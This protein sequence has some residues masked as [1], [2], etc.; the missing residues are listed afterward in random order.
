MHHRLW[1]LL[2]L[3]L[4]PISTA[5]HAADTS[6][7][8]RS[9]VEA[10]SIKTAPVVL[11][12][13]TLFRV[14]GVS[15]FPAE[16][17]ARAISGRLD[18]IAGDT[19]IPVSELHAVEAEGRTNLVGGDRPIMS[20]FDADAQLERIDRHVLAEIQLN[21]ISDAVKAY[22]QARAPRTL[23]IG[24]GYALAATALLAVVL[25]GVARV[26]RRAGAAIERRY[27]AH[28]QNLKILSFE[29]M[30]AEQLLAGAGTLL[31]TASAVIVLVLLY[32]Y[33]EFVLGVYPWTRPISRKLLSMALQ[34]LSVMGRGV[35]DAV[36]DLIFLAILIVVVRYLL[37][38]T[39]LFFESIE[40]GTITMSGFDAA[41]A[42]PTY[43][44]VRLL[45]LAFAVVVAYPYIPGSNSAAFKGVSILLGV[46]FSL[47]SSG[48]VANFVAGYTLIYRRAFK[49]GDRIQIDQHLGDVRQ[50]RAQVTH[51]RSLKNEEIILPNSMIL[52][53]H[54]VNYSSLVRERGLI[55]HTTVGIGYET[56]WR[57]VEAMLL[58]AA[59]RTEGLLKE[60]AP[61]VLQKSLDDFCVTYELN[62]HCNQPQQMMELY[63]ALHRSI[64]DVFNEHGVQIMTPAYV[65]DP[66]QPKVVPTDQWYSPPAQPPAG[67]G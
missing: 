29:I 8:D 37:R 22:R 49:V 38:M 30:R 58:Q 44:V 1:L 51:L 36:P 53:S 9:A 63:T 16:E 47:G 42:E 17:R 20:L 4:W 50:M 21:K 60:P 28:I 32:F 57:Q 56:P 10:E 43:R 35:V 31:R 46:M 15:A 7:T 3:A 54:V 2:W 64:L 66:V 27:K 62:V 61:F 48:M 25:L 34:P 55:L 24:T 33:L 6:Q 11:D 40:R 39:R 19:S 5:A 65:A 23:L 45:M 52:N 14:R 59:G 12:G 67:G 18:A 13:V 26:F 41:W